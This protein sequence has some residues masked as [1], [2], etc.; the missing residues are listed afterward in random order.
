MSDALDKRVSLTGDDLTLFTLEGLADCRFQAR[1]DSSTRSRIKTAQNALLR[2]SRSRAV[3]GLSTGVGAKRFISV[4]RDSNS[5][6]Q[7]WRSH[8]LNVGAPVDTRRKRAML[9][10]RANQIAK[11]GAGVSLELADALLAA[12]SGDELPTVTYGAS[13]G[14]ADLAALSATALFLVGEREEKNSSP[15]NLSAFSPQDALPFMS[16]SAL[17]LADAALTLQDMRRSID[18]AI[19]LSSILFIELGGNS[20]HLAAE[21]LRAQTPGARDVASTIRNS[22][23][24]RERPAS[25]IQDPFC[26]RLIPQSFGAVVD[27][28]REAE[29]AVVRGVNGAHENPLLTTAPIEA[30]HIGNFYMIELALAA[31]KL[32]SALAHEGSLLLNRISLSMDSRYTSVDDY[33]TDG[34]PGASGAMMLEYSAAASLA[35]I[36]ATCNSTASYGIH[37]SQGAEEHAPFTPQVIRRL[38]VAQHAY[39]TMTAC[40]LVAISRLLALKDPE[41][42]PS[43]TATIPSPTDLS[44]R[45]LTP[46]I[47]RAVQIVPHL[48]VPAL[49]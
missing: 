37:I 16:S 41:S 38:S 17:T 2:I 30:L 23:P 47:H 12:L 32:C 20:E 3:Y 14:T 1:F 44:D 21:G 11:G 29:N 45:N 24:Y 13:L 25:R 4:G 5:C 19:W 22:T 28:W 42:D 34:T 46:D 40:L 27:A 35:E 15:I 49:V 8:A 48:A 9:A 10:I 31:E 36:R 33:L 43:T 7:L 39:T 18:A 6:L 26:L